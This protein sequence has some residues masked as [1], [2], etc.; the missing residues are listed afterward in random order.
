M[1]D[2]NSQSQG[3]VAPRPAYAV[4]RRAMV[5]V[6][7]ILL[8]VPMSAK[9]LR[10]PPDA[11]LHGVEARIHMPPFRCSDW[12]DGAYQREVETYLAQRTGLRGFFVKLFNQA[13]YS[14]FGKL[15]GGD[16]TRCRE[17]AD[18]WLY[19]EVYLREY[20]SRSG[21]P[22]DRISLFSRR[23]AAL[24]YSL[25]EQGIEFLLVVAPSKAEVYPER[26]PGSIRLAR[27][28]VETTNAYEALIPA[29]VEQ[30][31]RYLDTHRLFL[32]I[33]TNHPPLFAAGGTHWNYYGVQIAVHEAMKRLESETALRFCVAP[34]IERIVWQQPVGTDLDL[35]N[36][37]NLWRFEAHG[38]ADVPYPVVG[39]VARRA[40]VPKA[41]VVIVGDSFG[42]T[43]VDALARTEAFDRIEFLYYFKR[44]FSYDL[45]KTHPGDGWM[46]PHGDFEIGPFDKNTLD[47]DATFADAK[48]VIVEV[49]EILLGYGGWRFPETCS[50]YLRD[51]KK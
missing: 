8:A 30:N 22:H 34:G 6:F 47:W 31:V 4:V 28:A 24:Q 2:G 18:S 51:R 33:K 46:L 19:E 5:A 27:C 3:G 42:F 25:A 39:P 13:N 48:V 16:G 49:N 41:K 36:I 35:R 43:L 17:G 38:M 37:L 14:L 32:D 23:L 15:A 40:G 45:I 44:R 50:R 20:M 1:A 7:C 9:V 11:R 10:W 26:L 29:L 21:M 12:F